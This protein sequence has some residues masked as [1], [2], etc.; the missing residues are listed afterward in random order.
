M[1]AAGHQPEVVHAP[2]AQSPMLHAVLQQ[3]EQGGPPP[4]NPTSPAAAPTSLLGNINA[5]GAATVG[6]TTVIPGQPNAGHRGWCTNNTIGTYHPWHPTNTTASRGGIASD[7][8]ATI[9]VTTTSATRY[10][11]SI[12]RIFGHQISI[13]TQT[14]PAI[15]RTTPPVPRR[16]RVSTR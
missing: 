3:L 5:K 1:D 15:T 8:S 14:T 11:S 13:A 12:A 4:A 9:A 2:E 16:R 7:V 10:H 6:G